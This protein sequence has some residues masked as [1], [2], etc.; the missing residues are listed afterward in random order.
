M[1]KIL[2]TYKPKIEQKQII[3]KTN[4]S[5]NIKPKIENIIETTTI[6]NKK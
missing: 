6:E 1:F 4:I 2:N 5:K 3:K